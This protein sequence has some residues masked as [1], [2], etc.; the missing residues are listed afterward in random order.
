MIKTEI[1]HI[2]LPTDKSLCIVPKKIN[3]FT[4]HKSIKVFF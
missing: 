4:V 3:Q 2:C 1:S